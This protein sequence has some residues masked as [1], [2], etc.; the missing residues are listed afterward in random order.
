[1][2]ATE[3][4]NAL[5][6]REFQLDRSAFKILFALAFGSKSVPQ[7]GA[8]TGLKEKPILEI[9]EGLQMDG[10]VSERGGKYS[11]N[12]DDTSRETFARNVEIRRAKQIERSTS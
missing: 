4:I 3:K 6:E 10:L 12:T 5:Y 1:M 8:R 2:T 9:L 11:W 7:L